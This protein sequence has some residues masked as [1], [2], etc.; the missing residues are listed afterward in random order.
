M[1]QDQYNFL[2]ADQCDR[3][4][5]YI[6]VLFWILD[7]FNPLSLLIT[8]ILYVRKKGNWIIIFFVGVEIYFSLSLAR[9]IFTLFKKV[10]NVE[11][12]ESYAG[13]EEKKRDGRKTDPTVI[14]IKRDGKWNSHIDRIIGEGKSGPS[15]FEIAGKTWYMGWNTKKEFINI[16]TY[17][18]SFLLLPPFR[19]KKKCR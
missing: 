16:L 2:D 10:S 9:E 8:R 11:H 1:G 12:Y 13:R 4:Y 15:F 17:I 19:R 18:K 7:L 3:Y 5:I 14:Y 6:P